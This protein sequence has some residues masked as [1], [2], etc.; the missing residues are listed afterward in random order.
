MTDVVRLEEIRPGVRLVTLN[1]PDSL[2]AITENVIDGLHGAFDSIAADPTCRVVIITGAGRGF[3]AGFDLKVGWEGAPGMAGATPVQDNYRG[4]QH[5]SSLVTRMRALPAPVIAAVNG[6]AAGGGFALA[7]A[8]DIRVASVRAK[9]GVANVKIGL[10]GGEM[11]IS[12]FLPRLVGTG[13][14]NEMM[15][16]GRT[17][18]A[19]EAF[20]WGLVNRVVEA[21]EVVP[22]A[23][24]LAEQIATNAP[25]GVALTKEMS[26]LGADA[27]SLQHALVLE[28]RT[29]ILAGFSSDLAEAITAFREGR[30]PNYG[31][32]P[33][34]LDGR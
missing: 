17:V 30:M 28:N 2:N 27:P 34:G 24:T 14:A 8:A 21:D 3:C 11:G 7:L 31:T 9:F 32:D 19:D 29:Q 22:A 5:L 10:S 23:V 16:T 26:S 4:Q 20:S 15:L 12:Y 33:H 18:A 1:R 6:A 25:F 13:R